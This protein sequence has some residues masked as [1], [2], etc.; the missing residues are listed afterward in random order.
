M[1]FN[2]WLTLVSVSLL[3]TAITGPAAAQSDASFVV[4]NI[5]LEGL[6]RISEGAVFNILPVDIGDEMNER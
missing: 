5:R 3:V 4:R 2:F 6:Q 1:R